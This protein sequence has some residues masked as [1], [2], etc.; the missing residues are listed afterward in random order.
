MV[1]LDALRHKYTSRPLRMRFE[2]CVA[3]RITVT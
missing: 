1:V 2:G 3:L